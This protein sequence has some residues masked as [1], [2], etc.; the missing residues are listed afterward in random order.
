MV[1][2]RSLFVIVARG[3]V[4]MESHTNS[5]SHPGFLLRVRQPLQRSA[6]HGTIRALQDGSQP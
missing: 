6:A 2:S 3:I 1:V 5:K 4:V